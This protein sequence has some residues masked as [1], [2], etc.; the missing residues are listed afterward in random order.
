MPLAD[1]SISIQSL[2][3]AGRMPQLRLFS[4]VNLVF[5]SPRLMQELVGQCKAKV[6]LELQMVGC[7]FAAVGGFARCDA[8]ILKNSEPHVIII[9]CGHINAEG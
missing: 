1:K 5:P 9:D 3:F 8:I 6:L 7:H 4:G 2:H